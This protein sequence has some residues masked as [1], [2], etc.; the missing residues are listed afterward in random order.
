MLADGRAHAAVVHGDK[1]HE[2]I[3]QFR[4]LRRVGQAVVA[5]RGRMADVIDPDDEWLEVP[6]RALGVHVQHDQRHDGRGQARQRELQIGVHH[7]RRPVL[8]DVPTPGLAVL[9]AGGRKR[10][11]VGGHQRLPQRTRQ[12]TLPGRPG[13]Q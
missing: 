3:L 12:G 11:L 1:L 5:D 13:K 9:V 4:G 8:L 10:N 6:E 7:Q 2:E